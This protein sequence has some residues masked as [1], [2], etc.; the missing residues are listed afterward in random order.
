[1]KANRFDGEAADAWYAAA[2]R[3]SGLDVESLEESESAMRLRQRPIYLQ[4]AAALDDW[5]R[6]RKAER[7]HA[8]PSWRHLLAVAR[9]IDPN[10]WRNRLR[11]AWAREDRQT[12]LHLAD[13]VEWRDQPPQSLELLVT[14]LERSD[15]LPRAIAVLRHAQRRHPGDFWMNQRLGQCLSRLTSQRPLD[16]VVAF[17]RA[18]VALRPG[19]AGARFNLGLALLDAG[20]DGDAEAELREAIRLQPGYANAHECLGTLLEKHGR[21]G[22]AEAEFRLAEAGFREVV[23]LRG[24]DAGAYINLGKV[25]HDGLREYAAA[26]ACFREALRFRPDSGVAQYNLG[27]ALTS[28]ARPAEA[29]TAYREAIRLMPRHAAAHY[30]LAGRLM[31]LKRLDEAEAACREAIRLR[32][33]DGY[34]HNRLA[35]ILE[36]RGALADAELAHGE[37]IRLAP[38]AWQAHSDFASFLIRSN[39]FQEAEAESRATLRLSRGEPKVHNDLGNALLGQGK[40][41]EAEAEYRAAIQLDARYV[42]AHSNLGLVRIRQQRFEEAEGFYRAAI[43]L[44]SPNA[45]H[46]FYLGYCLTMQARA[47]EAEIEYRQAIQ[48]HPDHR[49]AH[50]NLGVVLMHRDRHAD[51]IASWRE[52]LRLDP[53]SLK[54]RMLL[55]EALVSIDRWPEAERLFEEIVR[56]APLDGENHSAIG[57]LYATGGRWKKAAVAVARALELGHDVSYPAAALFLY[58]GDVDAYRNACRIMLRQCGETMAPEQ[59]ERTAKT[60]LL[61]PPVVEERERVL[62]LAD[63]ALTCTEGHTFRWYFEV[64]KALADYRA[65]RYDDTLRRLEALSPESERVNADAIEAT[66]SAVKAMACYQLGNPRWGRF[67]LSKA[68]L[69][70]DHS[71]G[72][73]NNRSLIGVWHDWVHA[74]ILCGE[75]ERLI[76]GAGA[77]ETATEAR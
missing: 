76:G 7:P 9:A 25:L 3:D 14:F 64:T 66:I 74:M 63:R 12:L 39:R 49:N 24:S 30:E 68:R 17:N 57:G 72:R 11:D 16:E 51:A 29:V 40:L 75:A 15:D 53:G 19:S 20:R 55:A 10:P 42:H 13:G 35:G 36:L 5:C 61:V 1:M 18:A 59:A 41:Q 69:A 44:D 34:A 56:L 60:C 2:F 71:A 22:E 62:E 65:G 6:L 73:V 77:G 54:I 38:G 67:E 46:R 23:R 50:F 45:N 32:P 31:N 47:E 58:T 48:L 37:A 52:A 21:R 27:H 26:E 4:L 33:E 70:I 43:A 8:V 28:L